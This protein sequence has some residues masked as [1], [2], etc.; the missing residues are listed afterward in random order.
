MNEM[1]KMMLQLFGEDGGAEGVANGNEASEQSADNNGA[2]N[3]N[4]GAKY[5]DADVDRILNQKFAKWEANKQKEIDEAARLAN[6]T[7]EEKRQAELESLQAKIAEL[8]A[9]DNKAKMSEVAR[10]MMS[11]ADVSA[12]TEILNLLVADSAEA[13]KTSVEAYINAFRS[14]V[15]KAVKAQLSG[16]SPNNSNGAPSTL[17]KKEI[18]SVKDRTERQRLINENPKL[19]GI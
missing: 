16:K 4:N 5:T 13:T 1:T 18:M 15:K 2:K 11:E 3:E 14:E 8:E 19:F 12:P 17:T 9:K 7:S 6:M 10:T